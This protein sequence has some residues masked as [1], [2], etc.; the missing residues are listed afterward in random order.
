MKREKRCTRKQRLAKGGGGEDD[1]VLSI[2][3]KKAVE[4]AAPVAGYAARKGLRLLGIGK[5]KPNLA[6]AALHEVNQ[7]A[8]SP[9]LTHSIEAAAK[10]TAT[11]AEKALHTFNAALSTDG[12][13]TETKRA[14]DNAAQYTEMALTSMDEPIDLAL[15]KLNEAGSKAAS[16][17][18]KGAVKV[19][20]S[21]LS[22]I[23]GVGAVMALGNIAD[24]VAH[25]AEQVTESVA[26]AV[27]AVTE[28]VHTL[29]EK[30]LQAQQTL[31][32]TQQSIQAFQKQS[33]SLPQQQ[34]IQQ[35]GGYMG[36]SK[37]HTCN[38]AKQRWLLRNKYR[39]RKVRFM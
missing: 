21:V 1:T 31:Q 15:D 5:R 10:E 24:N 22:A 26:D 33:Y 17:M 19:G 30:Q 29:R 4:S 8:D 38:R 13:K 28:V 12:M 23:P 27:D 18:A 2:V 20:S 39:T 11:I 14:L 25:T 35:Q 3:E 6:A 36:S 34:H 37:T 7:A 9:D 32:E 16:S